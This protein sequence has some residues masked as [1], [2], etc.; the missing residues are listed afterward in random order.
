MI[1]N[2]PDAVPRP[3]V[4]RG[5]VTSGLQLRRQLTM[6]QMG[7]VGS[8]KSVADGLKLLF[9]AGGQQTTLSRKEENDRKMFD[10][11]KALT[12]WKA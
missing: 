11:K 5:R 4:P 2:S 9:V 7:R 12:N 1:E 6:R 3:T 8:V 10:R